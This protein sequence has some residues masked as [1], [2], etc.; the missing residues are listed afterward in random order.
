MKCSE[1]QYKLAENHILRHEEEIREHLDHCS[2]CSEFCRNIEE[3]DALSRELRAQHRA[4][5]DFQARLFEGY[6]ERSFRGWFSPRSVLASLCLVAF[7]AGLLA[8]WD[9]LGNG[10]EIT[11]RILDSGVQAEAIP[12]NTAVP[13]AL[14]DNSFVEV[15]IDS[16]DEEDLIL[17][18]PPVI[19]IHRTEIPDEETHYHTVSY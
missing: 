18:L 10:G 9:Q 8:V 5:E 11:A 2:E 14:D 1:A 17:R 16:G 13:E 15:V 6:K 7:L 19:E 3:L 4:P 12:I